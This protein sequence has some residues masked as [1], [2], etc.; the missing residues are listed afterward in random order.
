MTR[1]KSLIILSIF[2]LLYAAYYWAVPAILDVENKAH[3]IKN[4]VKKELG[5]DIELKN[6]KLKMG[7]IPA[8]WL[9]ASYLRLLDKKSSPLTVT[10]PKLKIRLLPLLIGKINV[11]Y[12]SCDKIN[13]SLKFDK[14]LRFYLGNFLIIDNTNPKVSI[15]NSQMDI[16]SYNIILKDD[17]RK[18]DILINGNFLDLKK[19][20][21]KKRITLST[22]SKIRINS[23]DSIINASLDFKLPFKKGF[24]TNEII[25]DGAITNLNLADFSPYINTLSKGKIKQVNG[26]LNVMADTKVL[27]RRTNRIS[28]LMLIQNLSILGE[29]S[30]SYIKFK[31]KLNINSICDFSK[32]TLNIQK[33]QFLSGSINSTIDGKINKISSSNPTLNLN[34]LI[35]KS[36][37]QDF[38]ALLPPKNNPNFEVNI[39]ALKK[40]GYYAD[41]EGK[42]KITG[43]ANRPDI[44]GNILSTNSYIIKMPPI[45]IDKATT[46][47]NFLGEKFFLDVLVPTGKNNKVEVKGHMDLYDDKQTDLDVT[48]TPNVNLEYTESVLNPLHE[49]FYFE[50]GPLPT[51]KL[52]G[53]G[54][55]TLKIK[56]TKKVPIL[57]GIFNFKGMNASFNDISAEMTN[58]YGALIFKDRD[59]ELKIQRALLNQKSV[60]LQGKCS[61]DGKLDYSFATKGQELS[62]LLNTL[63]TSPSLQNISKHI[64]PIKKAEGKTD[65]SLR[66][67]GQLENLNK[68]ELGNKVL[69]SGSLKLLENNIYFE[70]FTMPIKN[71]V[72]N[73]NFKDK[74]SDFNLHSINDKTKIYIK[75]LIKNDLTKIEAKGTLK[76]NTFSLNGDISNIFQKNQ[77]VNA[78]F[79]SD[80][81]DIA[82]LKDLAQYPFITPDTKKYISKISNPTGHINL[83]ASV[84]N[85]VLNSK[86]KLNDI[87]FVYSSSD[88]PMKI[89]SGS[90]EINKDRITLYKVNGSIDSMPIL[91]DGVIWDVFKIPN[92]NIYVNSKPT[93]KF[94][95]KYINKNA[96]YP[97][98]IKGDIMY[99]SRIQG[100]KKSFNTKTEM[101]LD[102][103][104]S[105]YYMGST[106]G[107]SENPI[108]IFLDSNVVKNSQSST[109]VLNSFKYDKLITNENN[110]ESILPQINA[111]GEIDLLK[112]DISFRNLKI[113]TQNPTDAKIFNILFKKPMIK[114]GQFTSNVILNGSITS[115]RMFGNVDFN[116]I[117]IPL[118]DTTIKDISLDFGEKTIDVK[119]KGEIFSNKIILLANVQN[120]LTPPYV[121]NDADIYFGNLDINQITKR[122]NDL[123][124]QTDMHKLTEQ[125]QDV[126]ITN[127]TIK[128]AKLKADSILVKNIFAKKLTA[129]LSL[130]E[131]LLLALNNFKFDVA[132]GSVNGDFNYNLL[133][134]KSN[135]DLHVDNV[136]ANSMAE[137]LFDLDDQI[138]GS[139]TGQVELTCNGKTHKTCMDTLSGKGGFR[140]ADGRMP[141]LGSLEYLLKASNLVKSGITGITINSII[142]LIT[143]LKTGQF[144]NINGSFSIKSG[145]ADSIQIFSKGKDLSIFLTGTYNFATSIANLEVFGRVSKKISN[146]LGAVGNTSINTLFNSIPGVNLE[147]TNKSEF[148]KKLN[149]IPGFE[150]NDKTY[151]IFSAEIYG[152]INGESYVQ[153]FKWIE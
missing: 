143:P 90:A 6:P 43:K 86:I 138:F 140:V 150:L 13:A 60:L 14:N 35:N 107:D 45:G 121:I 108:R 79:T 54:N 87:S 88:I 119:S 1:L 141:K 92:F 51:M 96:S 66:L 152:D 53:N 115:P 12:F 61:L 10:N 64:P 25:F 81:F 91:I 34:I 131:K 47:I 144:E 148:V 59:T 125:K 89:L 4:I 65:L 17:F 20:N 40:Y 2:V 75:G 67:S 15:E 76:N 139:L 70:N 24:D 99:S 7:L 128:R 80:N 33:L 149:K 137:A 133:T 136:N 106:L 109:I 73:I 103:G 62:A 114:Q 132:Q 123:E 19:Y 142:E 147:E 11:A 104:S 101:N 16:G 74:Y 77:V 83:K 130:D 110:K 27:N 29:D 100:T 28:G 124:I 85:N 31:D 78:K 145:I 72:G 116:G 39:K 98:K 48:T 102:E 30:S 49:I 127:L 134:S 57:Q 84:K 42:L 93:Q 58:I 94:I 126:D 120:S 36:K 26:L 95:E 23:H 21:S 46:K 122:L 9:D 8:I 18:K 44:K 56:G 118:L 105:I 112:K 135:I 117:D 111:K 37:S 50:L 68:F 55:I 52:K 3:L 38:I 146:V 32:N 71:L 153:S 151:R 69:L 82:V 41:I 129:D 22:N 5:A 97:L 113:K 63:K